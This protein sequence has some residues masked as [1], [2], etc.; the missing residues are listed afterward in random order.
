MTF[1]LSFEG[2]RAADH[3]LTMPRASQEEVEMVQVV[4]GEGLTYACPSG[5]LSLTLVPHPV[6]CC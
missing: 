3:I 2:E 1:H 6:S 5:P 4:G